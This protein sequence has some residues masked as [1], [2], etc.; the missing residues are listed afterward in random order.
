MGSWG[1]SLIHTELLEAK[2]RDVREIPENTD[3]PFLNCK[4]LPHKM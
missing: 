3:L 4:R 2:L 1:E